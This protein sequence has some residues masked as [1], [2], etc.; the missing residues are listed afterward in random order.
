MA[1]LHIPHWTTSLFLLCIIFLSVLISLCV[2]G[3]RLCVRSAKF[4]L[5]LSLSLYGL[6]Y[7]TNTVSISASHLQV[8]LRLPRIPNMTFLTA[9]I[10]EYDYFDPRHH[11]SMSKIH[12]QVHLLPVA[13]ETFISVILHDLRAHI[14]RSQMTPTWLQIMRQNLIRT[15][16]NGKYLRLDDFKTQVILRT[17]ST[18]RDVNDAELDDAAYGKSCQLDSSEPSPVMEDMS[19]TNSDES[20]AT[21]NASGWHMQGAQQRLYYFGSVNAQLRRSWD[22]KYDNE[23]FVLVA[24]DCSWVL[25]PHPSFE[26]PARKKPSWLV[27]LL[28]QV[29]P[30]N[31]FLNSSTCQIP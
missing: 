2:S 19:S 13:P 6:S 5:S 28:Q 23:T 18:R 4:R 9:T 26:N 24:L 7:S 29:S 15:V 11:V 12:V 17:R 1:L 31:T 20:V 27:Y 22:P 10:Y 25:A 16:L 21:L 8:C 30:S 14:P 3:H